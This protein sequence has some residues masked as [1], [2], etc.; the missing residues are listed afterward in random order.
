MS[1]G[2][3]ARTIMTMRAT[4]QRNS[5]ATT[6]PYGHLEAPDFSTLGNPVPCFAW[7]KMRREVNDDK[8]FALIEDIRC[9]MPLDTDVTENDRISQ[10]TDR[11]GAV[12][13]LGPLRIDTIQRRHTQIEMTLRRIQS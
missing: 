11:L 1:V 13:F 6:D 3:R 2:S 7:S 4:V 8:K 10:I 5:T 12:L 9:A